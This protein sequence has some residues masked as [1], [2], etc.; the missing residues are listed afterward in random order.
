MCNSAVA[1]RMRALRIPTVLVW[2]TPAFCVYH[3]GCSRWP[4]AT[5]TQPNRWSEIK[6]HSFGTSNRIYKSHS[7]GSSG[8]LV[9]SRDN[10]LKVTSVHFSEMGV[11]RSVS[12]SRG[13]HKLN[14][15]VGVRGSGRNA[16]KRAKGIRICIESTSV[17]VCF[18]WSCAMARR[19]DTTGRVTATAPSPSMGE[20]TF[21]SAFRDRGTFLLVIEAGCNV[22][23]LGSILIS[24]SRRFA[25]FAV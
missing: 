18:K 11:T 3:P 7:G 9:G 20:S 4:A 10:C 23:I 25:W 8:R 14:R 1:A 15:N 12:D 17:S 24:P 21:P 13:R 6:A 22:G 19:K 2:S 16:L 5:I